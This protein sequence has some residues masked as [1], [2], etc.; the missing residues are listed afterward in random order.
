MIE[1]TMI[2]KDQTILHVARQPIFDTNQRVVAYEL[3]FRSGFTNHYSGVSG[4]QATHEV[5]ANSFLDI[6][7]DVLTRGKKAFINFT[8]NSL[9]NNLPALLPKQWIAIEILESVMPTDD[10]I[11]VCSNLKKKGYLM[12]LDDFVFHPRYQ[13]FIEI[14]DVIKVDFRRTSSSEK[15][16]LVQRLQ[17]YPIQFLAEKVES[18]EE[19]QEGLALGYS[20]FQGYFFGKPKILTCKN[21]PGYK[22]NYFNILQQLS[23]SELDYNEMEAIIKQ[24][25]SLSYK[26]LK[27]I[28]SAAFCFRQKVKSLRQALTLLG[29]KELIKWV[30][31]LALQSVCQEQPG[32]LVLSSLIRARFAEELTASHSLLKFR[33]QDAF[34]MGMFSH[35]DAL[36]GRPMPEALDSIPI[37]NEIKQALLGNGHHFFALLYHLIISYECG[38]WEEFNGYRMELQIEEVKVAQCY[39]SALFW[40]N[41]LLADS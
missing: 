9:Q 26:L 24:D 22:M 34:L 27:F 15:G 12:V 14:A 29:K 37:T 17:K 1:G 25:V 5:I 13:P 31:L 2:V 32:E 28:N 20:Y 38:N 23:R 8:A 16:D 36:L 39:R 11:E 19:F 18:Q 6:G 30:S 41:Q 7:I 21:I 40:A 3:L 4:D 33:S 10:V 35:L